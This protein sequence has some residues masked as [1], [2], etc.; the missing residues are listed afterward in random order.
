MLLPEVAEDMLYN[1]FMAVERALATLRHWSLPGKLTT[2]L[3]WSRESQL[4]CRSISKDCVWSIQLLR[5][6]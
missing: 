2:R 3:A 1:A 6:R 5:Q 4:V